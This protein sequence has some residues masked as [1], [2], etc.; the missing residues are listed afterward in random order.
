VRKAVTIQR[1]L[2]WLDTRRLAVAILFVGLFAMAVR[3]PADTDTWW[4]L[5]A[6][7]VTVESGRSLQTDLFSHTRE[8][9]PW[10]NASW[11]TQP[12]L[13]WLFHSFSYAGLGLW[14]GVVVT[15]T[16]AFVYLQ[17][18]GDP[19]T[20]AFI[21]ILAAATS[22]VVWIARPH[23]V[24][25]LLTAVLG[26]VLY[27]L[28]WRGRN[29][30]WLVPPL[31]VLWVNL[32]PGYVLGF[33]VLMAFVAG[34]VLNHLLRPVLPSEDPV[35]GWRE[36]GIVV[37]V[38]VLS[39]LLL[40]VNPN[41]TRM[42]WY[43]LDTVGI[44]SLRDFIQEWQSPDFHPLYAQPFIWLLLGTLAAMGLSG[45]RADGTDLA[46]VGGFAYAALLAGRNLGPFALVAA[47]VLSRHAS[48]MLRR[49]QPALRRGWL[50]R[51]QRRLPL[52]PRA[53]LGAVNLWLVVVVVALA[54]VKV[55]TPLSTGY[56]E[57]VQ[58]DSLPVDAAEWI[59]THRPGGK[60][61]N[62]YNWGG[63]LAWRLW[64]EYL[65]FVDGRTDLF[66]DEVLADYAAI[67]G[68]GPSA[69][70]LLHEYDV[71][72][73]LTAKGSALSTLLQ[74]QDEWTRTYEDDLAVIWEMER[75]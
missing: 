41:T 8:G 22:A 73:V 2:L 36:I 63:Y 33:M 11:L 31:F 9:S 34:E 4:H 17:M 45:R 54:V 49:C 46:M 55:L 1:L 70:S 28:K 65:V 26:Y 12:M 16:F 51:P 14:V 74:C 19:F 24:S 13:Y 23:L 44:R 75:R 18:E 66:G 59:E 39:A 57:E 61:F 43:Y 47:P 30:L 42:W 27:L 5:Q 3:A 60:M 68:A 53:I 72:F 52:R 10:V 7:R 25:F 69:I 32:H 6:G 15:A 67:Q 29:R 62:H 40:L 37:G 71:S 50:G 58:R 20:R 35:V 21:I 64:P 48:A 38:A 56:N